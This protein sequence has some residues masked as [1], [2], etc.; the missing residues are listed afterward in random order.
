MLFDLNKAYKQFDRDI[1]FAQR[2]GDT[3]A[4]LRSIIKD[5]E[6]FTNASSYEAANNIIK[7]RKMWADYIQ[8][9]SLFMPSHIVGELSDKYRKAYFK[10]RKALWDFDKN[11][12]NKAKPFLEYL[13]ILKELAR[14]HPEQ[15]YQ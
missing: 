3:S 7:Q 6:D 11:K 13:K 1:Q 10:M 4:V 12:D 2:V 9:G 8:D 15:Y 5:F 14:F